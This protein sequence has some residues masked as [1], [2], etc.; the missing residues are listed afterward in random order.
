MAQLIKYFFL[1]AWGPEF[2]CLRARTYQAWQEDRL[3]S[4]ICDAVAEN[5]YSPVWGH[6][7]NSSLLNEAKRAPSLLAFPKPSWGCFCASIVQLTKWQLCSL[8][9]GH[10]LP[11]GFWK[12]A[13]SRPK[14]LCYA[15]LSVYNYMFSYQLAKQP[16]IWQFAV[17]R[18][19][20]S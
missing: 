10:S 7:G 8:H 3:P 5:S 6:Q 12:L 11:L 17:M 16:I 4:L 15:E 20:L 18:W 1:K 14:A 9:S 13:G 2:L 19:T